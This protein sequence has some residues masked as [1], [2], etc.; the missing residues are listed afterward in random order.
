MEAWR[1]ARPGRTWTHPGRL[2]RAVPEYKQAHL[3][4]S[5]ACPQTHTSF[6]ASLP[7]PG[8]ATGNQRLGPEDTEPCSS[9][10][11]K[12]AARRGCCTSGT[13]VGGARPRGGLGHRERDAPAPGKKETFLLG[14]AP[15]RLT[16][17]PD[18]IHGWPA[19]FEPPAL[20]QTDS[21]CSS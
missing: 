20:L 18:H 6:V 1:G 9:H 7:G 19:R 11:G 14:P 12:T 21:W 8:S 3:E 13:D 17:P 10:L 5:P 16:Q 15:C 2:G 4:P